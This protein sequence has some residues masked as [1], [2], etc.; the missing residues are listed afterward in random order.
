MALKALM[1]RRR[2]DVTKKNLDELRAKEAGFVTREAELEASIAEAETA[3]EQ[4]ACEAEVESFEAERSANNTAISD[5]ENEIREL[6]EQ[7]AEEERKQNTDP[8]QPENHVEER[9]V[10][11]MPTTRNRFGITEEMVQREDA[12]AFITEIRTAMR[13]KR[14]IQ[15]AGLTI[16]EVFLGMIK[17]NVPNYS[18][19]YRRVFVRSIGGD[20]K[21]N[22]M[23]TIPEAVWTACCGILNEM[24]LVFNQVEVE[25]NKVAAF[26]PVCNSV[27]EDS[28]VN[29]A[30]EIME[31]LLIS[32]GKALDKAIV[33][34]TG[35]GMPLGIYTRLAQTSEP[36]GYPAAAPAWVDLHTT[37][38]LQIANSVTGVALFQ[39]LLLDS[40]VM[41]Q[42]YS[43]GEIV[44]LMNDTTL[45]YLKA[46]GMNV[47]AAGAI[48]SAVD[49]QMPAVGG[50]IEVLDFI[51]NYNIIAGYLDLYLLADRKG[52]TVESTQLNR[53]IE[54]ETVFRGKAR[55]DGLPVIAAAFAG[56]AINGA[57]FSA[58]TFAVDVANVP[59]FVQIDKSAVAVTAATGTN[60]TAQLKVRVLNLRGEELKGQ[61]V[62]WASGTEAKA[63]VSD[64]GL[65]TG[66]AAGSSVV[67]ASCGDAVAVCN[68]TVS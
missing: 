4:S 38:L 44:W 30:A 21:L 55:Y 57:S 7:L 46:Q 62:T 35:S 36:S 61:T 40:A 51:P 22:I 64:K 14:A 25:C 20:G 66:V 49:G 27:L 52:V 2:I 29:L 1:L 68:V 53:F 43:R 23:G 42:K 11:T 65:V 48:V 56:F 9:E 67:T 6:E 24:D 47:N 10:H 12:K 54:D 15:N 32:I 16:P 63:T 59:A 31:A 13:E 18:K 45:K 33:Y 39:T 60:H 34:G 8:V 3:E 5:L 19:L 17:E 50:Q 41:S 58:P 37:N 28:D 26:I